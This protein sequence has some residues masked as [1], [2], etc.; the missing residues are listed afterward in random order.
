MADSSLVAEWVVEEKDVRAAAHA[1]P[2]SRLALVR[3][4]IAFLIAWI[5]VG[6]QT[7]D[8]QFV[9]ISGL[10]IVA[11]WVIVALGMLG[12]SQRRVA[13]LPLAER[14]VRFSVDGERVRWE[15]KVGRAGEFPVAEL[16]HCREVAQGL[17][18]RIS[19][20]TFFIPARALEARKQEWHD[21]AARRAANR[22]PLGLRFTLGLWAFAL[23]VGVWSLFSH[24]L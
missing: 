21:L 20:T 4:P 16:T 18:L 8:A 15:S 19:G 10:V 12:T 7:V 14:A 6:L 2:G 13:T 3:W 11:F 22:W 17:L 23:L 1:V 9:V 24:K 5:G